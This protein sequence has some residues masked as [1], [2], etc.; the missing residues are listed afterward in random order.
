MSYY[1]DDNNNRIKIIKKEILLPNFIYKNNKIYWNFKENIRILENGVQKNIKELE[2]G[3]IPFDGEV[4]VLNHL[5][6][7]KINKKNLANGL[8]MNIEYLEDKKINKNQIAKIGRLIESTLLDININSDEYDKEELFYDD[9]F[10]NKKSNYVQD[11]CEEED[12]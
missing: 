11:I 10:E 3:N 4:N 12:W 7:C 1:I 6:K 5:I 8:S 2:L 9:N